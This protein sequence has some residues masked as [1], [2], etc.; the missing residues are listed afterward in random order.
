MQN[1]VC[2]WF[3][4]RPEIKTPT[5]EFG[6]M[7]IAARCRVCGAKRFWNECVDSNGDWCL[8]TSGAPR[9]YGMRGV[10]SRKG[11]WT[12]Y[13]PAPW[14]TAAIAAI[15]RIEAAAARAALLKTENAAAD[16]RPTK[17]VREFTSSLGTPAQF[18]A[19]MQ[20]LAALINM[21]LPV[22]ISHSKVARPHAEE[23]AAWAS[24][25]GSVPS[26]IP[27]HLTQPSLL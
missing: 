14:S 23:M 6:T 15:Q 7:F 19:D 17:V 4:A 3:M 24:K 10:S 27:P 2:D 12:N 20:T 25:L 22:L 5:A 8:M 18:A 1:H 11:L 16:P 9:I 13:A 26:G 21:Y